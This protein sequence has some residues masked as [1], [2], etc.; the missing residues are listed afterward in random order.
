MTKRCHIQYG[1]IQYCWGWYFLWFHWNHWFQD[2]NFSGDEIVVE[3]NYDNDKWRF[4][5]W[6]PDVSHIWEI[7]ADNKPDHSPPPQD[8]FSKIDNSTWKRASP[9]LG[10]N[11]W[12]KPLRQVWFLQNWE[13][14]MW[15]TRNLI[16]SH[17]IFDPTSSLTDHICFLTSEASS[18]LWCLLAGKRCGQWR[19]GC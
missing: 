1:H 15:E 19:A 14:E 18:P 17:L 11:A 10:W 16:F 7:V 4:P 3:N 5:G 2:M 6:Q 8:N 13:E 9:Q 12:P